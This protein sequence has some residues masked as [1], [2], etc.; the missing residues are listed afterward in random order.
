MEWIDAVRGRS[1]VSAPARILVAGCGV[2]TEAFGFAQRFLA[3]EVVGVD[4]SPRSIAMARRLQRT[5]DG[6]RRVRFEI[7]D[8]AGQDLMGIVGG[9]FDL[10]SCHGVLS[11]IAE[12]VRV[13]RNLARCLTPAGALVLGV[14]G[15]AHPSLRWRPM[16]A[17]FGIDA[18]EFRDGARVREVLR[19]CESL[20]FYPPVRLA[21]TPAG[22]L[23]GDLFGPLNQALSLSEW[24][25][26]CREAG[27]HL[28]GS[29]YAYF[30]TRALLNDDLHR[31]VM[32]R[33]RAEMS[34]LADAVQPMSFH[35]LVLCR[36]APV[37]TPW[38]DAKRLLD[39]RPVLTALYKHSRPGRGGPWHHLRTLTLESPST[40]TKVS[41]RVPQWEIEILRRSDGELSLRE[42]LRPVQPR[43]SARSVSEAMYLLYQLG[44]VNLV[45]EAQ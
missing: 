12:P 16:L 36:Q 15:A 1:P 45:P 25:R 42:I 7:A 40:N 4:F 39:W 13:L 23:A 34:E 44:V 43:V 6:G 32:P 24:S 29:Y 35:S 20:S 19:V 41:L 27:L 2:G 38:N 8:L 18:N 26:L 31:T 37:E 11:Y 3:A 21:E 28:H 17:G 22:Y 30:A 14:N 10:V 33:S 9:P 5:A